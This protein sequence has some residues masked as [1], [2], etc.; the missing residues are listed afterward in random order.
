[1]FL[2]SNAKYLD[3]RKLWTTKGTLFKRCGNP[4]EIDNIINGSVFYRNLKYI[5]I[6]V[7]VNDIDENSGVSVFNRIRETIE[8]IQDKY[9]VKIILGEITPRK[10]DKDD[11]VK[12][13]NRIIS[14]YAGDKPDI[15][16][17]Y[18]SNLRDD[19]GSFLFDNKHIKNNCI[20]RFAANLK[21]ALRKAYNI[22]PSKKYHPLPKKK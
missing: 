15:F 11:D 22:N 21:I 13:C 9:T 18:H 7:G 14:E 1:M 17:A 19:N 8:N 20:A 4:N 5:L 16:V 6:N 12:T 2:D 10:D 3:Y